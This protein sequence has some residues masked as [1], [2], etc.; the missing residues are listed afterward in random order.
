MSIKRTIKYKIS[1]LFYIYRKTVKE[2]ILT[3]G[4]FRILLYH[5]IDSFDVSKDKMGM[6][7]PVQ[8]FYDQMEYLKENNFHVIS[9]SELIDFFSSGSTIPH[10]TIAITF[11]DGFKSILTNA[12]PI[13]QEFGFS[14]TLF[15]NINFL[16]KKVP[17][18]YYC[19]DWPTLNWEGVKQLHESDVYIGSHALTHRKL[20]KVSDKNLHDEIVDSKGI[21][22]QH[23]GEN[24]IAFSYPHGAFNSRVKQVLKA[25]NFRCACT[26]LDGTNRAH[27][28]PYALCRT[29]ITAF[30]N[31]LT[32]FEKKLLGCFDWVGKVARWNTV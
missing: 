10:K 23:I 11:D 29:E 31:T 21:I 27:S 13:L 15:L 28:D 7:V 9:L 19:S 25:N 16:K 4:Q 30:D 1:D 2:K 5:S 12:L 24:I 17:K 26:S 3:N 14:A 8:S 6:A 18:D 20:T 32:K 22:E